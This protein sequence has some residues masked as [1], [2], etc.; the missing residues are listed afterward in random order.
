MLPH[1]LYFLSEDA[2]G[3][4]QVWRLE[5]DGQTSRQLTDEDGGVD[6]FDV[7]P[8]D[9]QVAY[10]ANN[11]LILI[12]A[13]GSERTPLVGGGTVDQDSNLYHFTQKLN[14]VSWAPDGGLLAYGL[15]GIHLYYTAEQRDQHV[16]QNLIGENDTEEFFPEALYSPVSWSADG[17]HLLVEVAFLEGASLA[18]YHLQD[19]TLVRLGG[20]GIVCC[21]PAW[22][23]D[24]RSV[25]VASPVMGILPSGLWRYNA[26]T[27]AEEELI[28]HT[29]E[30]GTLNFAAWPL[31][32]ADDELRYFFNNMAAFPQAEPALLMV[33]AGSDAISDRAPLRAEYWENYEVLWAQDGHLAVAVQPATGVEPG[34]PRTG[35]IVLIPATPEPVVP[36]LVNGH[37]LRWGP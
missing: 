12:N 6:E 27:G 5:A 4:S 26:E 24:S 35:P 21:L 7:S 16:I 28:H 17:Q 11:Q 1:S 8:A 22:T 31:Q 34:W 9:G 2:H 33:S 20:E 19:D 10:I 3:S 37:C 29:S 23:P 14:G 15:N 36:L 30:D 25:L 32:S 13:A 18:V